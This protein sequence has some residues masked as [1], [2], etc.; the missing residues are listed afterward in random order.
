M[1]VPGEPEGGSEVVTGTTSIL[2]F[3]ASILFDLGATHL[4]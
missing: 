3:E 2:G 1:L 4:L